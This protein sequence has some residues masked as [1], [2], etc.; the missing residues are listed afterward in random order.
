M[1]FIVYLIIL[2]YFLLG[3]I[4]FYFID[5]KK[6]PKA[7]KQT[8][9]K[10]ISYFFIIHI[11]F[12]SIVF[13]P[14]IFRYLSLVIIFAGFYELFKLYYDC[15]CK[16]VGFFVISMMVYGFMAIFFYLFSGLEMGRIL[17]TFLIVSIFDSFS[18]ITGQLWGRKKLFPRISPQKTV[19][20]LVGG[21]IIALISSLLLKNLMGESV[22]HVLYLAAGTIVSGFLGDAATSFYKRQYKAKD[23]SK[24]IPGH[25]GFLDR[26]DSLL[27]GGMWIGLQGLSG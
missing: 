8:R 5:R 27:A 16:Q 2:A 11:L 7:R 12:F 14:L 25:G 18:Q 3:G 4:G 21:G 19:G 22:I 17:F 24:L 13:Q 15:H 1:I 10:F 26:F 23:F 20:G 6:E 9:I